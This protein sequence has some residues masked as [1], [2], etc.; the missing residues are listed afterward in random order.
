MSSQWAKKNPTMVK[1][2][3]S[4]QVQGY[5]QLLD[6]C[7]LPSKKSTMYILF[8]KNHNKKHNKFQPGLRNKSLDGDRCSY[9]YIKYWSIEY[10]FFID[11]SKSEDDNNNISIYKNKVF[12][13]PN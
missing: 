8:Y 3:V 5:S 11:Q 7:F 13:V 9:I 6:S 2:L 12:R 1:Y 10:L 4:D